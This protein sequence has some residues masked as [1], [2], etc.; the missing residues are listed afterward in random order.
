MVD[1]LNQF[2]DDVAR[3]LAGEE[4]VAKFLMGHVMRALKGQG[5]AQ[6]VTQLLD[7]ELANRR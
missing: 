4:K 2:P 7:E 5:N 1:V 6:I 3:W